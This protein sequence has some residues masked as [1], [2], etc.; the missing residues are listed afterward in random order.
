MTTAKE[1]G[2]NSAAQKWFESL[3]YGDITLSTPMDPYVQLWWDA[4]KQEDTNGF[5]WLDEPDQKGKKNRIK[6]RSCTPASMVCEDMAGLIYNETASISLDECDDPNTIEWLDEWLDA[7]AWNDRAPLAI[8]RMCSTGTAAWAL[9]IANVSEIGRSEFLKVQPVRYDA[10]SII[11]LS[12]VMEECID[13]A[14]MSEAYIRGER[15]TQ[16][17]VHK[18]DDM[19][20]NYLIYCAFFNDAGDRVVPPGYLEADKAID[21]QQTYPTFSLIKLAFDNTYWEYSPMGVALFH[22]A[23]DVLHTVDLAFNNLGDDIIMGRKLLAFPESMLTKDEQGNPEVPTLTGKRFFLSVKSN[24][25]DDKLG[26]YEYNPSLR[27]DE[28]TKILTMALQMLGKRVGFGSKAYSIDQSGGLTT[29]TQVASDNSEMM[30]AVRRHEHV[31]KPAIQSLITAACGVHRNL[32][33][34]SLADIA[35]DVNVVLGD[36]IMQDD[37]SLRE[38]DRADVAAGL[39]EPWRY[40]VRWQGYTEEEA[41]EAQGM[42]ADQALNEPIEF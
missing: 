34:R 13:C 18:R 22:D 8:G 40:M 19:T 14:F 5:Y 24:T 23:I 21:T 33:T 10:R 36:S 7:T 26:V 38:R 3:G 37:D 17:E 20:G 41:K 27:A 42:S 9:H 2:L 39:L 30:R 31:I 32:S 11:P 35:G 1:K 4:I 29:A 28:N 12:W 25:Y 6:V 16:I 15:L